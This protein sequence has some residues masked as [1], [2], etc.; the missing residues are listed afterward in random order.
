VHERQQNFPV[1]TLKWQASGRFLLIGEPAI[2]WRW[3]DFYHPAENLRGQAQYSIWEQT[4]NVS[5]LNG[6]AG[7]STLGEWLQPWDQ[8]GLL[9]GALGQL[10]LT[11]LNTQL[12]LKEA[13]PWPKNTRGKVEVKQLDV[14]GVQIPKLTA[15][16]SQASAKPQV[17]IQIK[18]KGG[19]AQAGWT[20]EGTITLQ[21]NH[22]Y[23]GKVTLQAKQG[24]KLPDWSALFMRQV[25][26]QKAV[27]QQ[28]G[29]W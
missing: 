24:G 28:Q 6:R 3:T 23:Q 16:L 7:L 20:L 17:P 18:L 29:R 26:P 5:Q 9:G 10:K 8:M 15:T 4:L 21:A 12:P 25:S 11:N 19:D 1:A 27:W 14:M 22:Q 2:Q 13:Q